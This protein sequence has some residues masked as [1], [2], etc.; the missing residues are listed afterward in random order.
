M[1]LLAIMISTWQVVCVYVHR[2]ATALLAQPSPGGPKQRMWS[3]EAGVGASAADH[4]CGVWA[5]SSPAPTSTAS[6]SAMP[7]SPRL[8]TRSNR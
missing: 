1:F 2:R 5:C 4:G 8:G 3:A 6:I 7:L